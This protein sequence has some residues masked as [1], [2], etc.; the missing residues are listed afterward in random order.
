MLLGGSRSDEVGV[1]VG[2]DGE[3]EGSVLFGRSDRLGLK[4]RNGGFSTFYVH[5]LA[6]LS[7]LY[8][9]L[10]LVKWNSSLGSRGSPARSLS[11]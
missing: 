5:R 10:A 7:A 6:L 11:K 1:E 2:R 3:E 4:R 8:H 9:A